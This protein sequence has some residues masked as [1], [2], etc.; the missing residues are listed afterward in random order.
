MFTA[1]YE[2]NLYVQFRWTSV[3]HVLIA[4]LSAAL[5]HR[6]R[7]TRVKRSDIENCKGNHS[8]GCAVVRAAGSE[9]ASVNWCTKLEASLQIKVV[10]QCGWD[11][12]E[13]DKR[14]WCERVKK[15]SAGAGSETEG[16]SLRL[17][18]GFMPNASILCLREWTWAVRWPRE[19][20][21]TV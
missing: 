20:L 8:N 16:R 1:R 11:R 10:S 9:R 12:W 6:E 18:D 2:P 5:R 17:W 15:G 19:W 3:V 14:N 4:I 21:C 13:A 7:L